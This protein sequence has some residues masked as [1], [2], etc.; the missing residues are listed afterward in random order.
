M[1][2]SRSQQRVFDRVVSSEYDYEAGESLSLLRIVL[3]RL[4]GNSIQSFDLFLIKILF[5]LC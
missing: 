2:K 1:R 4:C 3:S 5:N